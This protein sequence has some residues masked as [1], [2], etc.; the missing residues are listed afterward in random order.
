[1]KNFL[2]SFLPL[3]KKIKKYKI[4][5]FLLGTSFF[6]AIFSLILYKKKKPGKKQN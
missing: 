6:I 3:L 5:I 4:E 2:R 1:M